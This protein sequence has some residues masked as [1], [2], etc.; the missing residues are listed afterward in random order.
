METVRTQLMRL[1]GASGT[2]KPFGWPDEGFAF[3]TS[4]T[5]PLHDKTVDEKTLL[6]IQKSKD[7]V[8][9]VSDPN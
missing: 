7:E 5:G 2:G 9:A 6:A 3:C 8:I 1:F 4:S